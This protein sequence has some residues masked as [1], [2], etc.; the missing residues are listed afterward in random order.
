MI[1]NLPHPIPFSFS[2]LTQTFLAD[3]Q[4]A[5]TLQVPPGLIEVLTDPHQTAQLPGPRRHVRLLYAHQCIRRTQT[6]PWLAPEVSTL[7]ANLTAGGEHVQS[8]L[9]LA[10]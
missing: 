8:S 5:Q 7:Q 10:L 6:A 4:P 1:T 3:C 2:H 9:P